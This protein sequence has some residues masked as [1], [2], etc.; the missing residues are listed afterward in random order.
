MESFTA[1]WYP[2][3]DRKHPVGQIMEPEVSIPRPLKICP[4]KVSGHS[5]QARAECL[6]ILDRPSPVS[7]HYIPPSAEEQPGFAVPRSILAEQRFIVRVAWHL[8]GEQ[9]MIEAYFLARKKR[10]RLW[11]LLQ[12]SVDERSLDTVR[13]L[14]IRPVASVAVK[15][16]SARQAAVALLA[17]CWYQEHHFSGLPCFDRVVDIDLLDHTTIWIIAGQIWPEEVMR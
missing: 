4:P 13:Y 17:Y 14:N 9:T 3:E 15:G 10:S 1:K 2:P 16:F 12:R 7:I 11:L 5:S 6:E 8:R